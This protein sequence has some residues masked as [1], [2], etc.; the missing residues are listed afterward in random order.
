MIIMT[1]DLNQHLAILV[2]WGNQGSLWWENSVLM[3]QVVLVSV[4]YVLELAFCHLT[5]SGF[6]WSCCL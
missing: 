1:C 6:S 3:M 2:C 4:A 5:I